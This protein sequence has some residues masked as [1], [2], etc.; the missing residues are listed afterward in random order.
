MYY[1][2]RYS[3]LKY[4]VQP[5]LI[6]NAFLCRCAYCDVPYD[7]IGKL[8]SFDEDFRLIVR[9][10]GLEDALSMGSDVRLNELTKKDRDQEGRKKEHERT[11]R[12][13][14]QLDFVRRARIYE[15]YRM[16]FEM[17]GYSANDYL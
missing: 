13:L 14:Q 12:Y 15:L 7:V 9:D 6:S 2:P 8:E 16:D 5:A 1:I 17:F 11:V 10:A 4:V 3:K